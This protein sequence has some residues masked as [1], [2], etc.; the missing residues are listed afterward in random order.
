MALLF[1]DGFDHYDNILDKWDATA[2]ASIVPDNSVFRFSAGADTSGSLKID[3]PSGVDCSKAFKN[4]ESVVVGVA[5]IRTSLTTTDEIIKLY[6]SD[7]DLS[8]RLE[9]STAGR[10]RLIDGGG[11]AVATSATGV[12]TGNNWHFIEIK[13]RPHATL[14]VAEIKVDETTVATFAGDT[15]ANQATQDSVAEIRLGEATTGTDSWFDDLYVLDLTGTVNNDY[16]G[17][18]RV[19][20]KL[21]TAD[22]T[23]NADFTPDTGT[24]H[25]SRVDEP[26]ILDDDTSYVENGTNGATDTFTTGALGLTG[27]VYGVQVAAATRKTDSKVRAMKTVVRPGVTNQLGADDHTVNATYKVQHTIYE[28]NPDT[29]SLWTVGEVDGNEFGFRI[30]T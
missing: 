9:L 17:D 24:D 3:G 7:G 29:S 12:V 23:T 4:S 2:S 10:L 13:W 22:S 5:F 14:G 21:P 8:G 6:D 26:F 16:L 30:T 11:G 27:T 18:V 15:L 1:V 19:V 20:T 28:V 25:F